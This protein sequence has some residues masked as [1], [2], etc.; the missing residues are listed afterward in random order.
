MVEVRERCW[1]WAAAW[2]LLTVAPVPSIS[3]Q[4][5]ATPTDDGRTRGYVPPPT[6]LEY[7]VDHWTPYDPPTPPEGAAVH[8]IERGDT[9]WDLSQRYYDDPYLWPVIWDANRYV[10]YSHWIYPGDP[11]VVPPAPTVV[12]EEGIVEMVEAEPEVPPE[13]PVKPEPTPAPPEQPTGPLLVPAAE[14]QEL[15]CL[16]QLY[17]TF[18]PT[19]LVII[20]REEPDK[21]LHASGDIVYLSAGRDMGI[22]PGDEFSIIRSEGW[23]EHPQ[24]GHHVA[25]YVRRMGM[26][27]VIAVQQTSAT[28]EIGL[29][30]DAIT[31]GDVLQ[32]YRE[33]PVPMIERIPLVELSSPQAGE[34]NG[35]VVVTAEP[36][37]TVAGSGDIVGIDLGS[38]AGLTAGDRI[39]F[40]R[41]SEVSEVR[42]V[43][44]QGVVLSANGGGSTVK[45]LEARREIR[46]GDRAE[47]L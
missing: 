28:A 12:G 30:C 25:V 23:L 16:A 9:L 35:Y 19:P 18:D 26:L 15:V 41:Q 42:L 36:E 31:V 6:N 47:L 13:A 10:T 40:W 46:L 21:E 14:Q 4:E 22:E 37:A 34:V 2:L 24:T 7:K 32:P 39:L 44:A 11:L 17:D 20:G 5:A 33:M 45:V 27:R 1:R 43:V 38:R 29:S 3:A 8:V